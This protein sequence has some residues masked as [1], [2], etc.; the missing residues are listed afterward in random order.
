MIA[1]LPQFGHELALG[2]RMD[3][4]QVPHPGELFR[5]SPDH[6]T[7]GPYTQGGGLVPRQEERHHL[8][9]HLPVAHSGTAQGLA[10]RRGS[11]PATERP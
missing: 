9:T 5:T 7:P 4:Q 2:L 3:A 8:I 10:R 6:F 1:S 11:Y